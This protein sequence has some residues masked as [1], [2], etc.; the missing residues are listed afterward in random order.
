[1]LFYTCKSTRKMSTITKPI[2]KVID[3][4]KPFDVRKVFAKAK[5]KPQNIT[6][7]IIPHYTT[8]EVDD[9]DRIIE[10]EKNKK[11]Y[12]KSLIHRKNGE[13]TDIEELK[14]Q[15]FTTYPEI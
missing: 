5:K 1:M 11:A 2:T 3:F 13:Y 8:D 12:E 14:K 9:P 15:F 4:E 7:V 10:T 6:L